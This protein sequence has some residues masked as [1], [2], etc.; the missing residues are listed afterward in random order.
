MSFPT[1]PTHNQ[2][3]ANV[4]GTSYTYDATRQVWLINYNEITG[5]TGIQGVTGIQ[6]ATGVAGVAGA[7]G[8]RG[9]TGIAGVGSQGVTGIGTVIG[10]ASATDNAVARYNLTTGALLQDSGLIIDDSTRVSGFHTATFDREFP[11]GPSGSTKTI[12]W[13]NG[14]KQFVTMSA[15]CTFTFTAPAGTC[16][17]VLKVSQD[18]TTGNKVAT[19]PAAVLAV[20]GKATGLV[21]STTAAAVDVVSMYYNGT[22]YYATISKGFAA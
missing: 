6:G 21:L 22:N 11:I 16:N 12:D 8:I 5:A 10:P 14:N 17:L 19:W 3:Y 7:T 18:A 1:S 20:G 13:G 9:T 2:A 15:N 4:L